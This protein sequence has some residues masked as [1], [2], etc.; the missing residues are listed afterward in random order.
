MTKKEKLIQKVL[1]GTI[2]TVEAMK[3]LTQIGYETNSTKGSHQ[4]WRKPGRQPIVLILSKKDLPFFLR[5]QI[6][7]AMRMEGI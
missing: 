1:S 6:V 5:E 2:S 7:E 4:V 3:I